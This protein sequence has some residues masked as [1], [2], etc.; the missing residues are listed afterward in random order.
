MSLKSLQTV[1]LL[2][3]SISLRQ[4]KN[5]PQSYYKENLLRCES[6]MG[7]GGDM[8]TGYVDIRVYGEKKMRANLVRVS[9]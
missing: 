1:V 5:K 7:D 9:K 2:I 8:K 3:C 4:Y 6:T